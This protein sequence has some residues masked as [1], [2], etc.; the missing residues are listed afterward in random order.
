M[1]VVLGVIRYT[2]A[3]TMRLS[4]LLVPVVEAIIAFA[5]RVEKRGLDVE[6]MQISITNTMGN[7][8]LTRLSLASEKVE[9]LIE[10]VNSFLN[11]GSY[12]LS[13]DAFVFGNQDVRS[14]SYDRMK[15]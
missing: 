13:S 2:P 6:F 4:R 15:Q 14:P 9:C 5:K 11:P 7:S 1:Q 3:T 10:A 8:E 12:A